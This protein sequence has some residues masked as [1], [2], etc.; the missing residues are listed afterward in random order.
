RDGLPQGTC[1][2][3]ARD[4]G[5]DRSGAVGHRLVSAASRGARPGRGAGCGLRPARLSSRQVNFGV[6]AGSVGDGSV[7]PSATLPA[8]TPKWI[9]TL[10]QILSEFAGQLP[11]AELRLRHSSIVRTKV[12]V[13][14]T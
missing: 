10:R 1:L 6:R 4:G 9:S 7:L 14:Q 8:R 11:T 3:R 2:D 5:A 13:P 12:L